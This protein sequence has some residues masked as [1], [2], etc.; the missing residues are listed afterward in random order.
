MPARR[1]SRPA[2][3]PPACPPRPLPRSFYARKTIQVA[4]E[5]LGKHLVHVHNGRE[6][7]ARIVATNSG[8]FAGATITLT[9]ASGRYVRLFIEK[10]SGTAPRIAEIE[11]KDAAGNV[12]L[13]TKTEGEQLAGD[14]LRLT[15]SDRITAVY[16]DETSMVSQG[17]PRSL[18]QSLQATYYNG[19]IDFIAYDFKAGAGQSV[20]ETYVK[21]V[22]RVEPGQ[23][24]VV[25]VTDYDMDITDKRDKVKFTL[26]ATDGQEM[27]LEATE[28]EDR[29]STRLNSSHIPLSRM[30][31]SA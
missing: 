18:S 28:T 21:Q 19:K 5:L 26:K 1:P 13:P 30:P 16:E 10:F 7:R 12:L 4:R 23:R 14:A 3:T 24:V 15:P 9:N 29:K 8:N 27:K 25:R 11:V 31:S 17:K 2:V 20:P 22:R 6:Q